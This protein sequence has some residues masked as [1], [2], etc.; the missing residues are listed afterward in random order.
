VRRL[1]AKQRAYLLRHLRASGDPEL[2]E[3]ARKLARRA[4]NAPLSDH[5]R[6]LF[7]MQAVILEAITDNEAHAIM[8]RVDVT[9]RAARRE[10]AEIIAARYGAPGRALR[11]FIKEHKKRT[12]E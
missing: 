2:I 6:A 5:E 11:R 12:S 10:A 4:G 9:K 8:E 3:I 7:H 1:T